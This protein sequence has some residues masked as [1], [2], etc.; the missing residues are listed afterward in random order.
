[1]RFYVKGYSYIQ[2]HEWRMNEVSMTKSMKKCPL[3]G[4]SHCSL[5]NECGIE[6]GYSSLSW[7]EVSS[8]N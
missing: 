5:M 6:D 4:Y 7:G 8:N 3:K 2:T 1:M